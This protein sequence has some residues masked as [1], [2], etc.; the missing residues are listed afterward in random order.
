MSKEEAE[1]EAPLVE[2]TNLVLESDHWELS[3]RGTN[4]LHL[5]V[6]ENFLMDEFAKSPQPEIPT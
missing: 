6:L 1:V 5:K 4:L 3:L 2:V